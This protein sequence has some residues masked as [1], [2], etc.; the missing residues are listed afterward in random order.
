M[1]LQDMAFHWASLALGTCPIYLIFICSK[2]EFVAMALRICHCWNLTIVLESLNLLKLKLKEGLFGSPHSKKLGRHNKK[3][4]GPTINN[5]RLYMKFNA[6][7]SISAQTTPEGFGCQ[8]FQDLV[9]GSSRGNLGKIKG[10]F[11]G[12]M[13]CVRLIGFGHLERH[14]CPKPKVN[15]TRKLVKERNSKI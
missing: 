1:L 9:W 2:A 8:C 7:H 14:P 15:A 5:Q 12:I 4:L 6:Q 11:P 13:T 10:W 3:I